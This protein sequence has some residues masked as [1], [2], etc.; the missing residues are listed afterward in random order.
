M[1]PKTTQTST[2]PGTTDSSPEPTR[3]LHVRASIECYLKKCVYFFI[4]L[5]LIFGYKEIVVKAVLIKPKRHYTAA[6][7]IYISVSY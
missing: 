4:A 3:G 2:P 6:H 1:V 7:S 5:L